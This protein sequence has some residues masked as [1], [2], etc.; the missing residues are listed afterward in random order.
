[1][2]KEMAAGDLQ[3]ADLIRLKKF[4]TVQVFLKTL[5]K[6]KIEKLKDFYEP[7]ELAFL[8]IKS[9]TNVKDASSLK[10]EYHNFETT[11]NEKAAWV[12][13]LEEEI[14]KHE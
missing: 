12:K 10:S 11:Y 1:M 5:L 7:Y 2:I 8:K 9:N 4:L 14:S 6:G 13:H 3:D